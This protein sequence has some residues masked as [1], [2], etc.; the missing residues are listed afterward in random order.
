MRLGATLLSVGPI[1][2][3]AMLSAGLASHHPTSGVCSYKPDRM[4]LVAQQAIQ[5]RLPNLHFPIFSYSSDD[6]AYASN[7]QCNWTV[8][9]HVETLAD[10]RWCDWGGRS[11]SASSLATPS[12]R[13]LWLQPSYSERIGDAGPANGSSRFSVGLAGIRRAKDT[14]ARQQRRFGIN[15]RAISF[16][17]WK[18]VPPAGR[19]KLPKRQKWSLQQFRFSRTISPPTALTSSG[20]PGHKSA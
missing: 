4:I 19:A 11:I 8:I 2:V 20:L 9:G 7:D 18:R 16:S 5:D 6:H 15:R 1:V 14:S 12:A 13:Q 3:V 10:E 17:L